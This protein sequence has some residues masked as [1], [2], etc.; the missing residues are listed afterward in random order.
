ML[1]Y[2]LHPPFNKEKSSFLWQQNLSS[3]TTAAAALRMKTTVCQPTN[4]ECSVATWAW[5]RHWKCLQ[6]KNNLLLLLTITTE[7]QIYCSSIV[8]I[9]INVCFASG[10]SDQSARFSLFGVLQVL[11]K[12]CWWQVVDFCKVHKNLL[13][14]CRWIT[15]AVFSLLAA[16]LVRGDMRV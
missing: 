8:V 14:N 2:L 4:L 12:Y 7:P 1:Q 5:Q 10:H 13:F 16:T 9:W 11:W 15:V 6:N 3:A